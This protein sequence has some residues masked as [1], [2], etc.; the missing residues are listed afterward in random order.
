MKEFLKWFGVG[1]MVLAITFML[2]LAVN[3]VLPEGWALTPEVMLGLAAMVLSLTFTFVPGLRVEFAGITSAQKVLVNLVSVTV[4]SVVMFLGSCAEI[5]VIPGLVCTTEGIRTLAV[6]IFIAVTGNQIT[7][8]ASAQ[9]ADV[10]DAKS[11]RSG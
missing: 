11:E 1:L 3:T 10:I 4:L 9:P 7:Y 2:L 8:I 6:Y 5:F